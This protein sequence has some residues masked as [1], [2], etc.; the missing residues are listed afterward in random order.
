MDK[1]ALVERYN[2]RSVFDLMKMVACHLTGRELR[3]RVRAPLEDD[4]YIRGTTRVALD[5]VPVVDLDPNWSTGGEQ[6]LR[7]YLHEL[8]HVVLH[9]E[10]TKRS[11]V[12]QRE[13]SLPAKTPE[14]KAVTSSWEREA[15]AWSE[16]RM[17]FAVDPDQVFD[18]ESAL[19]KL[20]T[21]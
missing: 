1:I 7:T 15:E 5:G 2:L 3:L 14:E 6:E 10:K 9:S 11:N 21:Y 19:W 16:K 13:R 4:K 20:L 8:A 18:F 12:D 17:K